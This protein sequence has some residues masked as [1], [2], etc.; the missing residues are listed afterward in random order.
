MLLALYPVSDRVMGVQV[1][2]EDEGWRWENRLGSGVC[3]DKTGVWHDGLKTGHLTLLDNNLTNNSL[4]VCVST[5]RQETGSGEGG[6][7]GYL[8]LCT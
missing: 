7:V 8:C 4:S 2:R 3:T 1:S 6:E 5:K